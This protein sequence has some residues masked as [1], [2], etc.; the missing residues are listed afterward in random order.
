MTTG[1]LPRFS[2]VVWRPLRVEDAEAMSALQQRCFAVDGGHRITPGE[3][4]EEFDRHGEHAESDSIGAFAPSGRL[5]A[6]GWAQVPVGGKTEHRGFVW[7]EMDPDHRGVVDD[8]LLDWVERAGAKRLRTFDDGIPLRLY[9]YGVYDKM[10]DAVALMKRHGYEIAR[11]FTDNLRDLSLPIDNYPLDPA[12]VARSWSPQVEAD[13]LVVHNA[14]FSDHWGSQPIE[15][16]IWASFNAGEFFEP[17][18]SWVAYDGSTPVSYVMTAKY[19]HDF[20]DRGR[21]EAWIEGVGTLR[22][23]RGRGIASA[24]ITMAIRGFRDQG[25]QFARLGVDSE[26]PTGANEIYE[27]LGFVPEERTMTFTKPVERVG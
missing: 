18:T 2:D 3:M 5:L 27:R 14:A 22:S 19:P 8:A 16:N 21:T 23:H 12:I 15:P 17:D 7:L 10:T 26:N 25:L 6:L 11:Y 9:R 4:R 1:E 13:A 20:A 24:L